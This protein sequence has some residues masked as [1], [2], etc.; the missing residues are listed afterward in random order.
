MTMLYCTYAR[1]RSIQNPRGYA[2]EFLLRYPMIIDGLIWVIWLSYWAAVARTIGNAPLTLNV[3]YPDPVWGSL[4]I[5]PW[6]VFL[7]GVLIVGG[8]IIV[9]LVLKSKKGGHKKHKKGGLMMQA[10]LA[11]GPS[12]TNQSSILTLQTSLMNAKKAIKAYRLSAE[13]KFIIIIISFWCQ[14]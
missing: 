14:W 8:Y 11:T 5:I 12:V 7:F 4:L 9:L 13:T 3:N 2:K 6:V 1:L 10:S